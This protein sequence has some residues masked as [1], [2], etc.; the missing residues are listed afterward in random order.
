VVSNVIISEIATINLFNERTHFPY[1][2][3]FPLCGYPWFVAAFVDGSGDVF[4]DDHVS[5]MR[6]L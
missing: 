6:L 4:G 3:Q 1:R 5:W 2:S